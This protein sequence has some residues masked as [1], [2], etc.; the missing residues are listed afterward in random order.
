MLNYRFPHLHPLF[1]TLVRPLLEYAMQACSQ[2]LV[3]DADFLEQTLHLETTLVK[4]YHEL[5]C[6]ER[7]RRLG[8]RSLQRRR[9]R[10][11]LII[12]YKMIES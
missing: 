3:A 7:L 10:G 12:V 11:D 2:N 1:N 4:G 6:G 5:L 9:I 8:L